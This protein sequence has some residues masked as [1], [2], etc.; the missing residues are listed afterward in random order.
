MTSKKPNTGQTTCSE[1]TTNGSLHEEVRKKVE[2][3]RQ[4]NLDYKDVC[5]NT[6]KLR[7]PLI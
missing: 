5:A 7:K 6:R 1:T 3:V 4:L 2:L